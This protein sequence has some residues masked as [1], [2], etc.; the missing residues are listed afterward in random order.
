VCGLDHRDRGKRLRIA[1]DQSTPGSGDKVQDFDSIL[2]VASDM[3]I[4][5]SMG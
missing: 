4:G 3:L 1:P 2:I 5:V